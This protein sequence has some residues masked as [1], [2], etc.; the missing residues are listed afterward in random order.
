MVKLD[1]IEG[2]KIDLVLDRFFEEDQDKK[3]VPTFLYYVLL[4]NTSTIIGHCSA[5]LGFNEQILYVGNIGFEIFPEFRGN[6][7]AVETVLLLKKVFKVNHMNEAYITNNIDNN[8]SIRVC[9]KVG[10]KFLKMVEIPEDNERRIECGEFFKNIWL[11][12]I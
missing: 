4:H 12:E 9:E 5:S 1:I 3:I 6:G 7:Y 8:A 2:K 10:A 11:L